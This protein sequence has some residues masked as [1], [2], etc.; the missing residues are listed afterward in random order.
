MNKLK[1]RLIAYRVTGREGNIEAH[2]GD[3]AVEK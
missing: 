3:V 2:C 1:L